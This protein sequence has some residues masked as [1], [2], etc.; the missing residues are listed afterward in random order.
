MRSGRLELPHLAELPPEDSA[1]TNF[2]TSAFHGA[3]RRGPSRLRLLAGAKIHGPGRAAQAR[4][5]F[6]YGQDRLGAG[7]P[8]FFSYLPAPEISSEKHI[9]A[10]EDRKKTIK[11]GLAR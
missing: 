1:S 10:A 2:A 11:R 6:F 8:L 9:S 3:R 5:T 4:V 7:G